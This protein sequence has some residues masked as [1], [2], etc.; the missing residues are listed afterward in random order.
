VN[1]HWDSFAAD[2]SWFVSDRKRIEVGPLSEPGAWR[3]SAAFSAIFPTLATLLGTAHTSAVSVDDEAFILFSWEGRDCVLSWLARPPE[4]AADGLYPPHRTLLS[5]FGGVTERG[6]EFEGQ[7]LLNTNESLTVAEASHDAA[8]L[9]D[10]AWAFEGVSGGIPIDMTAYYSISREAN[11]NDTLCH[12]VAGD[13]LMFAPDHSFNHVVP[14]DGCPDYTLY[15][16]NG[17]PG[18]VQWV[19]AVAKQWMEA[20]ARGGPTRGIWTPPVK[21]K[22]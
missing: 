21:R 3:P 12:R 9:Q 14:L 19:E 18:F 4:R 2:L 17:A 10:Y 5:E 20:G 7:W 15:R 13:V 1:R 16:I 22:A 11:G 6:G 8:F